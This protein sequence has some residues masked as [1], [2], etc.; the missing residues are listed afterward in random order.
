MRA[1]PRSSPQP[2]TGVVEEL[3]GSDVTI[4]TDEGAIVKVHVTDDT[5]IRDMHPTPRIP[6]VE[7]A[8]VASPGDHVMTTVNY[9]GE[10]VM[11][12]RNFY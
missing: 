8:R 9:S 12:R 10:A 1:I 3:R 7:L 2:V 5:Y 4:R 11:F 6:T